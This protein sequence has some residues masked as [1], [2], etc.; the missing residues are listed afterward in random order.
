MKSTS[1]ASA[2][3]I[4]LIALCFAGCSSRSGSS[5][6]PPPPPDTTAPTVGA[7]QAP[8]GAT[9]NRVVTLSVSASDNVGVSEVRFFVDGVQLGVDAVPPFSI[10]WDTSA[11][12]EGDHVLRADAVDAAGNVGQSA[13][14]TVTVRNVVPFAVTASGR[15]EVTPNDSQGSAT[16]DLTVNLATGAVSGDLTVTG[17][18]AT[19]A[20]VHDGFAGTNGPVLVPFEQD[21]GNAA[22][23]AIP[24][25][26]SLDPAG[27]D[28]LLAGALYVNV[29]SAAFPPGELR[30]QI[31]PEN[32]VLRFTDLDGSN[33]VP[34]V[35]SVAGG[36]AAITLDLASGALVV[37]ARV[38]ALD[39]ATVAHVHEAYAGDNGPVTAGLA[40]DPM[41]SG[42]WFVEDAT[43]NAA[44]L[45]AFAAG[46]LYVNIHSPANPAGEIRGQILPEGVT[47]IVTELGGEQEVP[48]VDT[49][50]SGVASL[51]L[52][53]AA[54]LLTVHANTERLDDAV[55]AHLHGAFAGVNGGVEVGLTQDG[56][57]P[58]HWF[59]EEAMLDAAQLDALLAGAT[60]VN[61]HS[62][63]YS[64]GEIRGQ[65]IPDGI[66]FAFG[67]LA[68]SQE[69]PAVTTTAGGTFAVTVDPAAAR[70][71]AHVNTTGVD[72]AFAAHLH[73]GYAGTNGG[74]DIGLARDSG[75][76]ARW[77]AIDVTL[78][79]GQLDAFA[80]GRWYV[81]VHTQANPGGEI[82][83]QVAPPPVEVLFT[84]LSGSE[85]VPAVSTTA[86]G[87]AAS[88][89]NRE[90]GAVTLHLNTSDASTATA[91]HIHRGYAGQ[92]GGVVIGLQQDPLDMQRWSVVEAQFDDAGLASYLAGELYVNLHTPDNPPGEIRGQVA[93][94]DIRV[95]FGAMDGDQVVP[96][97]ATAASGTVATTANLATRGLVVW[98]N[99]EGVDDATSA[100]V[101]EGGVGDNGAE[102]LA[103]AQTE[104]RFD[105]WS[106]QS[107][108]LDAATFSA[109]RAGRLYAQIATPD[110][111]GGEIR[112]QVVPPDAAQF[113]DQA[114]TVALVSPG[115]TVSGIVALAADAS[116]DQGVTV[117]RFLAD[118]ALIGSDTT[119]PFT[120]DWDTTTVT[121]GQ[122]TLTAEADDAAGNTGVSAGVTVT[123]QNG[124]PVTLSQIQA[125]VFGPICSGCHSGPTGNTLPSGMNLSSASA[126][127]NALVNVPS[128]QPSGLDRVEPGM[129][130]DS[131]LIRKLEG[132]PNI[133]GSRMPQGGPFLDQAVIDEIRQWILDDAPNN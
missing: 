12:T 94:R 27:V 38:A 123:V 19:A 2:A 72:N 83:G 35:N 77:S 117:V 73:D 130:D 129:P 32:F 17:I 63:A 61:V 76:E 16:A 88:T 39:D 75:N 20:H 128:L 48:A 74:V 8:A 93:P 92:N 41:D 119:S 66:R 33:S 4:C 110:Q 36:R 99:A 51:T 70:L 67:R 111:S 89:V 64:G 84:T 71:V 80:S 47:V 24:A 96:P 82:R 50:A 122:V 49:R 54:G 121:D 90:T 44:G 131:Y 45:E 85:E 14:L 101:H 114:P 42:R 25:G 102:V 6:P 56:S 9:V 125:Q 18:T 98:V 55:A 109:Y 78:D 15:E 40:K 100:G 22:L 126:S 23:F 91:S 46:R 5:S 58:A 34:R 68:G 116:D 52:D 65:V 118:G 95:V 108:R 60:Y 21:A 112:G 62:T 37:Q 31:L 81:N 53:E 79:A 133:T 30:G 28:R 105:Q 104:G 97:V 124:T 107:E 103:L 120:F 43:L 69:V 1:S 132:G 127:F 115:A 10:D 57:N 106:G 13:E 87:T 113:D 11:E 59:V 26:S 7:V 86:S 29:H 3:W